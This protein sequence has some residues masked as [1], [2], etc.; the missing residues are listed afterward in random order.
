MNVYRGSTAAG[1]T[2]P[3]PWRAL[4]RERPELAAALQ[5]IWQTDNLPNNGLVARS[6]LPPGWV[7]QVGRLL[8]ALHQNEE[9]R[10]LLAAME[11]SRFEPADAATYRP[12][13][14][15]LGKF[16]AQVRPLVERK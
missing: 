5:V 10:R 12:V 4:S 8:F 16:E 3:P 13:R 11:L 6:D 14:A 7:A 9:G 15:F 2:W 1:A